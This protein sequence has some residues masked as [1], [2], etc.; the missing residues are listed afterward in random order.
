M[1]M[2][3][4]FPMWVLAAL[5]VPRLGSSNWA[6]A[7]ELTPSQYFPL[8]TGNYWLYELQ[9]RKDGAPPTEERWEIVHEEHGIFTLHIRQSDLTTGGFE[10]FFLPT[11]E[12]I[13]RFVKETRDK[14]HPPFFLKS[15]FTFGATWEDEDGLYEITALDETVAVPAGRFTHCLEV[16]NHR[17]GGKATVVTLYAPGVGIVKRQ[18]TFPILEG[19]GSFYPQRQDQAVLQLR[20]WRPGAAASMDDSSLTHP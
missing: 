4:R 20:E 7:E 9:D 16:T 10:E 5:I 17:K 2:F 6:Q 12:G 15:P 3:Q 19:S 18:E 13:K 11:A 14:E 8:T 1:K